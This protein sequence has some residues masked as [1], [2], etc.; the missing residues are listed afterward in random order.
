MFSK[1]VHFLRRPRFWGFTAVSVRVVHPKV[2]SAP[3]GQP[4]SSPVLQG[5]SGGGFAHAAEFLP[6]PGSCL[7]ST[8]DLQ[9]L[10]PL[11]VCARTK[12][13]SDDPSAQSVWSSWI[14]H[15]RPEV[16]HGSMVHLLPSSPD[17]PRA[18]CSSQSTRLCSMSRRV[19]LYFFLYPC[20]FEGPCSRQT[21][22]QQ[23][24]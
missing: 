20:S 18:L 3:A 21:C 13:R 14:D 19:F 23:Q 9:Q 1:S 7:S 11:L 2:Q 22:R 8:G 10:H 15:L 5:Q 16:I 17:S 6:L 12:G 24:A 4:C